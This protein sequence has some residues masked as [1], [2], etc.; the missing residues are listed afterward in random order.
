MVSTTI[1]PATNAARIA[2]VARAAISL[3]TAIK[4][5][6]SGTATSRSRLTL[7][8]IRYRNPVCPSR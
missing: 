6:Q 4:R 7:P 3:A 2:R 5:R 8:A 1:S